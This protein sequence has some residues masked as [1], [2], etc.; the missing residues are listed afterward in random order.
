MRAFQGGQPGA[1]DLL[2]GRH[3]GR[4]YR[5]ACRILGDVEAA[6]DAA[7][8]AF[9][10]AWRALP[11]FK[12][13]AAFSTWLTRITINQCRNELRRRRTL[14]HTRPLSLDAP[15]AD[16]VTTAGEQLAAADAQAWE[17]AGGLE[18]ASALRELIQ[19]LDP[20]AREILVLREAEALSYEDIAE[21]LAVPVGTVRSRLHRARAELK[22]RLSGVVESRP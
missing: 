6:L 9:V 14:K 12:G 2:M 22:R 10:R 11:G 13:E 17:R 3:Q 5:L 21:I 18:S 20:E 1:F 16:G 15:G 4:V 8:E 7:Q 19:Q